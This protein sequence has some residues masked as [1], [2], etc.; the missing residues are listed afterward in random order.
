MVL[1]FSRYIEECFGIIFLDISLLCYSF[2]D[3]SSI[4]IELCV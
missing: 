3:N 1:L 2:Y 4:G